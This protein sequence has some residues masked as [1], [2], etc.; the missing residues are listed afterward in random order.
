V[1]LYDLSGSLV[2][3]NDKAME[4]GISGEIYIDASSLKKGVYLVKLQT[5]GELVV[6]RL[7]I[8]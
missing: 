3:R 4:K 5:E 1:Q 6:R 8:L 7:V 2:F